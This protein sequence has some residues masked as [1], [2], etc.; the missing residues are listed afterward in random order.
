M[1]IAAIS[2]ERGRTW[3]VGSFA[4]ATDIAA[5]SPSTL[6]ADCDIVEVRLDL[7]V[8]EGGDPIIEEPWSQL[9]GL[10]LLFTARRSDEGG[11]AK[12]NTEQRTDL[13]TAV[14]DQAAVIDIEVASI[15]EMGGLIDHL[16]KSGTPWIA[17][18]HD[19]EKL[20]DT[21]TM[22][23]AAASARTAG[24]T[25]FK[26]AAHLKTPNDMVRL[27][28]FQLEDHGIPVASMGMGSLAPL[29]RLL[30]AQ[31]GSLLNYGFLGGTPTAPGQWDAASLKKAIANLVPVKQP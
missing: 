31:C 3:V 16:K 13:L 14:A 2:L 7:L 17:S 22:V 30:C 19:F 8:A 10:P 24:A 28:E 29:S 15:A 9:I 25:A 18:F 21:A 4:N 5:A 11:A 27:A 23:A 12:L 1:A 20:P 6:A 26:L